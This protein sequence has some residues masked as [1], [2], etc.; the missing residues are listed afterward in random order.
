MIHTLIELLDI[1]YMTPSRKHISSTLIHLKLD[2]I[3]KKLTIGLQQFPIVCLIIDVWSS[4]KMKGFI[5]INGHYITDWCLSLA[6][7]ACNRFRAII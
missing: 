7:L 1:R 4:W 3:M 2:E 6:M 5:G